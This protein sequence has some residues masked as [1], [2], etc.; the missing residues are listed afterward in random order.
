MKDDKMKIEQ[1]LQNMKKFYIKAGELIDKLPDAIPEKTRSM[2]KDT[3]LGDKDLK[4]LM[5]GIDSHRPPRIFLIGRTGVGKSS[6]INALC[7]SY[8]AGVSDTKSCTEGAQIYECKDGDRVLMEILDT[9]GIAESESLDDKV[10]AEEML[11]E[12]INEFSPDVAIFMLNC[13]HRDDVNTDVE[14]LKKVSKEYAKVNKLQLPIVVVINKC[15]EMAPSR[16]KN[17][18][19]YPENKIN[20][21]NEVVQYYKGIIVK[22]GLK[23]DN[24]IAVSSLIDWQTPDGMEID[25]DSIK[26]LP[27]YD[28]DNLQIAFD[29]RYGIEELLDI[30]EEAILDFEA[31]M[32]LRMAS[33]L[34][35]VV[36]RLAKHLNNIF[37]GI[38][39]TVALTP[40]PVSDIYILLIIQSMLVCLIASLSGRDIS[41]D[42]GKEFIFSMGGIAGAGYVFRLIAQQASKFLNAIFIGSGSAVSSGIAYIGTSA[43]GK[44]AIAYYIENKTMDEAKKQFEKAKQEHNKS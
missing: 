10:T 35:E 13:T 2:L 25:V 34:N 32:G 1:R 4:R 29:G 31:Q 41:L 11:I 19:E 21:I 17:P 24:I 26:N 27:K 20:K 38:S 8:V 30:L 7:G 5:E 14:F 15:D 22:N 39:A 37:S 44:A 18:V 43:I 33:R 3:I 36:K 9:R 6:M 16:F 23:I 12:Q 42:T 28:I 40:I